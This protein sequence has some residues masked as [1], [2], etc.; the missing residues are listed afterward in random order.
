MF[1]KLHKAEGPRVLLEFEGRT[2][3]AQAGTTVAAA[4]LGNGVV[5]WRRSPVDFS[6]RGP[7]CMIGACFE[8]M[9]EIDG[10]PGRQACLVPVREGMRVRRQAP[11]AEPDP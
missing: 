7:H 2:L 11:T 8:C 1:R 3:E 9:V 10:V 6:R 4:L 5:E